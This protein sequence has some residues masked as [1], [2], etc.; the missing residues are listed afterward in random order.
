MYLLQRT[1]LSLANDIR[2]REIIG[3]ALQLLA[4][5]SAG[6][7]FE[8]EPHRYTLHGREI[9]SVSDI[10]TYYAPFNSEARA[11]KCAESK[12]PKSK[13]Y[14]MTAE[15]ILAMWN[16]K[17]DRAAEAGTAVHA[18]AEACF[19]WM[20]GHENEIEADFRDRI[21][22]DGLTAISE[23]EQAAARW[24]SDLDWSRYIIV[25]KETR[26]VNPVLNYAGTFDLLLYDF[27]TDTFV[28]KDYKT[29]E[30]LFKWFKEYLRAPLNM[31]KST[32][33]GKYTLQQN[34]YRIQMENIGIPV[35]RMELIWL[36]EDT[37]YQEVRLRE[38]EK[39]VRYAMRN[40]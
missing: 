13:Y 23:K 30:D 29:N 3:N 34:L 35:S 39:L 8:P 16:D 38:Y 9:P 18:F 22:E 10:V 25:A 33:E 26:I 40:N 24:W 21:T 6:L 17:R 20:T 28:I 32:D 4:D 37:T 36:K 2:G 19:L 7:E 27:D 5:S 31:I 12:D 15:E 1:P 14:G 11:K